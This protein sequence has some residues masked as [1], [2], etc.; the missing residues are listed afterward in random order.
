MGSWSVSCGISGIAITSGNECGIIPLK[1]ASFS[2]TMEYTPAA[3]PIFGTYNDYGGMENIQK[4]ENTKLLEDY[5]GIS[6]EKFVE[7]LVDGKFTY[8]RNEVIPI[9]KALKKKDTLKLAEDLRF[10]WVDRKVYNYAT[11]NLDEYDKGH[12]DYGTSEILTKF[13][14]TLLK[15]EKAKNY[16]AKRFNQVWERGKLKVFSDGRT[17]LSLKGNYIFYFGKGCESSLETYFE[18]PEE[19]AYLKNLTRHEAWRTMPERMAKQALG[20]I[21]G[22]R[23]ESMTEDLIEML[24]KLRK[25]NHKLKDLPIEVKKPTLSKLYKD[26][27]DK[28]GDDIAKLINLRKNLYCM[29]GRFYPHVLYLTPQCGEREIHQL[30]LEKFADINKSYI[31]EYE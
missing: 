3:L 17:M 29:S 26:N 6:I 31:Q 13:G 16:D 1:K 8:K 10:M 4:D 9:E 25:D 27:L 19:F 21:F 23:Y 2:E 20:Y 28:F 24:E 18:V 11:T 14:F 30:L 15:D 22:D 5:F 12:M 7:F